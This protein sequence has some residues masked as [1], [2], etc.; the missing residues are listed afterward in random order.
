RAELVVA[1]RKLAKPGVF[2]VLQDEGVVSGPVQV[3]NKLD[4]IPRGVIRELLQFCGRERVGFDN[5]GG[6]L[7]LEVAFELEGESVDLVKRRLAKS[8]LQDVQ[9]LQVVSVIPIDDPQS[10]VRPVRDFS[11]WQPQASAFRP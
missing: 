11:F 3:R 6:A 1:F 8:R 10:K 7:I 4:V 5:G 2:R 9:M